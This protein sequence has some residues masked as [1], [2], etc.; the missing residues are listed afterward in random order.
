MTLQVTASAEWVDTVLGAAERQGVARASLLAAAGL[1]PGASVPGER[2]PID[3]VARLWHAAARCT[4]DPGFG[5]KVGA[6]VQPER[7]AALDPT[8]RA[9]ATLREAIAT[10]Q[11][12][13]RLISDGARFQMIAGLQSS[14][15]V[16]HPL[17]G[18][19]GF[20]PHQVEAV[21]AAVVGFA[22]SVSGHSR[23][24]PLAVQFNQP[25]IGPLDG[26]QSV[27][28]C[29]VSFDQAFSGVLLGN[30]L[31]DAP[32]PQADARQ[33][34]EHRRR[35]EADLAR[36][37]SPQAL[38][39]ELQAWIALRLQQGQWPLRPQAAQA[40]G[41][42]PRTLARR[43]AQQQLDFST[44][45]D[46]ARREAALQAVGHSERPLADIG[47]SLGFAEPSTFWRA[48]RRWTGTTPGQWRQQAAL[49]RT[50]TAGDAASLAAQRH[51][52]R[53]G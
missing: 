28:R 22:R 53:P 30:A 51:T 8:W 19:L 33:A 29:P 25:V 2:W 21:L 17:Q 15:V 32:L 23:L 27:F 38:A 45:L 50:D 4:A 11:K 26:Y 5:L 24:R 43:M 9:C 42:S 37:S 20:S 14:W 52:P 35:A 48:F 31:L 41:L 39:R 34:R 40:L 46:A 13:Q 47:Q 18:T 1:D 49:A 36:L 3:H 16:Y 44:L 6:G 10:A 12:F 7:F